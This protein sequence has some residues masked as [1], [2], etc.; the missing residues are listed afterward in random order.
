MQHHFASPKER[1]TTKKIQRYD[2]PRSKRGTRTRCGSELLRG[3]V[4]IT[5]ADASVTRISFLMATYGTQL[6]NETK[7]ER[8]ARKSGD[9]RR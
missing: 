3:S 5:L 9:G 6:E 7:N 1:Q 8:E 4:Q 2:N